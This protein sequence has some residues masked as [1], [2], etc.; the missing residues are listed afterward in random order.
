MF[1][2]ILFAT[3]A[4][5]AC[6]HAAAAA[7]NLARKYK[8][9][10][11]IFHVFGVPTR[12]HGPYIVDVKTGQEENLTDREYTAWIREEIRNIYADDIKK[13]QNLEIDCGVGVPYREILRKARAE[14]VD[15]IVMG[16]H[17]CMADGSTTKYRNVVGD[18][19]QYVAKNARCPVFVISRPCTK[20]L[21]ETSS[22]VCATD[23]SKASHA[24]FLFASSMAREIGC[25]LLIFHSVDITPKHFGI[26][27]NQESIEK[28]VQAAR[29]R[30]EREYLPLMQGIDKYEIHVWEGIP[31]VELL[32]F[33][34]ETEANLLVMAHRK[35][36]SASDESPLGSM[37]EQVVL[38]AS[39]P[40]VSVNRPLTEKKTGLWT[41]DREM[42]HAAH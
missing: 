24:A 5:P 9:R 8:A 14:D 22:I 26:L 37:V 7:F 29:N 38:R 15:A 12:G 27:E 3:T 13:T 2:K 42:A 31:H 34:R 6:D 32:K 36:E 25:R 10:L 1:R 30:I 39:C 23:F 41:M 4:S 18:T 35:S 17:T 20:C 21:W 19:L 40:V 16:S 11:I 28:K 33:A